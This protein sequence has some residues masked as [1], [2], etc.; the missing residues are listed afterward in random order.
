MSGK[1]WLKYWKESFYNRSNVKNIDL[2]ED[3]QV[4]QWVLKTRDLLI[5]KYI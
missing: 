1:E 5:I 2:C 4:F 3:K